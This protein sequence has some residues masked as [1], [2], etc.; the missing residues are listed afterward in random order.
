M[1]WIPYFNIE[2]LLSYKVNLL[3]FLMVFTTF[4]A[5]V[6]AL[7]VEKI[8]EI[9]FG[10]K[11]EVLFDKNSDRCFRDDTIMSNQNIQ[12]KGRKEIFE[13][14][15]RAYYRLK[16]SNTGKS[17][18]K[19]VKIKVELYDVNKKLLNNFEP[20][21]LKWI[22]FKEEETLARDE[23]NYINL[24]SW[25][26]DDPGIRGAITDITT[27]QYR[28]EKLAI[29]EKLRIGLFDTETERSIWWDR[30][31]DKILFKII[32]FGGNFKSITKY[33]LFT[34]PNNKPNGEELKEVY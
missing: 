34:K 20:S 9:L 21:T 28:L 26:L 33:F 31:E 12:I 6:V 14:V 10:P 2:E 19:K 32:V 4:L 30:K 18:A 1:D 24:C 17:C 15:K 3:E 7:F 11:I 23:D 27:N 25:L 16:V 22:T 5:V 8:K 29:D 13:G